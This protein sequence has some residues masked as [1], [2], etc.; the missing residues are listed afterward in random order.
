[1]IFL[2]ANVFLRYLVGPD[3]PENR[4][5]HELAAKLIAALAHGEEEATTSEA[6]VAEV[7]FILTSRKHYDLTVSD[8]ADYLAPIFRLPGLRLPRGRKRLYLR[9]LTI[10]AE[11]PKLGF[12]DAL[13]A[14][15][16]EQ[17]AMQLVTF[18]SDFDNLPNIAHW[19]PSG[20]YLQDDDV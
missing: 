17:T 9:T 6:V 10:W 7:A 11:H 18:D 1:L 16:V 19:Q 4:I 15:I 13:T 2:D 14:A 20:H 3:T 8:A 12:V 5:R